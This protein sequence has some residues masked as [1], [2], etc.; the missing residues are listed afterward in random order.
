MRRL[1]ETFAADQRHRDVYWGDG[2]AALGHAAL[3]LAR[4]DPDAAPTLRRYGALIDGEHEWFYTKEVLPAFFKTHG[5][6]DGAITLGIHEMLYNGGVAFETMST[7][8]SQWG[9]G[10]AVEAAMTPEA[11]AARI[12]AELETDPYADHTMDEFRSRFRNRS[13]WVKACLA[14]LP[15]AAPRPKA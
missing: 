2:V 3:A 15:K 13:A 4:L 1:V 6:T 14:A 10:K 8:W 7:I 5:W 9:M 12:A 11:F